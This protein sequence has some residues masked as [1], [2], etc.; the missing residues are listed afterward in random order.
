MIQNIL[1]KNILFIVAFILE[2][3]MGIIRK[4]YSDFY[5]YNDLNTFKKLVKK[6]EKLP[7]IDEIF[8]SE[9]ITEQ[10]IIKKLGKHW[11]QQ[12][13]NISYIIQKFG[14]RDWKNAVSFHISSLDYDFRN[15][16]TQQNITNTIHKCIDIKLLKLKDDF[17]RFNYGIENRCKVY[18]W[19][20]RVAEVIKSIMAK[21][22]IRRRENKK[23][24][25]RES[26][27]RL[28]DLKKEIE[29][30]TKKKIKKYTD[31]LYIS[32][33]CNVDL[34][35][36]N[37]IYI[38]SNNYKP[39]NEYSELMKWYNQFEENADNV[40]Y[41]NFRLERNKNNRIKKI[42]IRA[43]S[44]NCC[45]KCEERDELLINSFGNFCSNDE[46]GSIYR[47]TYFLNFGEW[48]DDNIDIY[49]YIVGFKLD[50]ETRY[51]VKQLCMLCYFSNSLKEAESSLCF[52]NGL[53]KDEK[54]L[55]KD[56]FEADC[57]GIRTS[58]RW[59]YNNLK[60]KL[61]GTFWKSE[62]F[63][64]E[65]CLQIGV[66]KQMIDKHSR[67]LRV[68]DGFYTD[69][70]FTRD[71]FNFMMRNEA[72]R[73]QKNYGDWIKSRKQMI[74]RQY[75]ELLKKQQKDELKNKDK[76]KKSENEIQNILT[77]WKMFSEKNE[78][79]SENTVKTVIN[80]HT[81]VLNEDILN[82]TDNDKKSCIKRLNIIKTGEILRNNIDSFFST[83]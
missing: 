81:K 43:T 19:N 67:C 45:V 82:Y 49:E 7:T 44:K 3:N 15:I 54:N 8:G 69:K 66:K 63:F 2:K 79:E 10:Y 30:Q 12:I 16:G 40:E 83:S 42:S 41:F 23:S 53:K 33:Q 76:K 52:I 50:N 80:E 29:I 48:F 78:A 11:L 75:E 21:N 58:F 9:V 36:E 64:H 61:G 31:N 14:K 51:A 39:Y 55:F 13:E 60:E 18:Y 5:D 35:D 56:I 37:A 47:T 17:F 71:E 32:Q 62:I 1:E 20:G 77:V 46:N 74:D 70:H 72:S 6:K 73:Y 28:W 68:Y 22:G 26:K 38:L 25:L 4:S 27:E 65:S 24:A 59:F 34:D 57:Q